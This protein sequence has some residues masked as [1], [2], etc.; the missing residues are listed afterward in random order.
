MPNLQLVATYQYHNNGLELLIHDSDHHTYQGLY[1]DTFQEVANA[2]GL[3]YEDNYEMSFIK[4]FKLSKQ[5][6]QNRD[7]EW[8]KQ[9]MQQEIAKATTFA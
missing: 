6:K 2:Y 8:F 1:Y 5:L 3:F 9:I 7:Q 4:A